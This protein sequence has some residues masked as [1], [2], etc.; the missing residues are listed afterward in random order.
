MVLIFVLSCPGVV[1]CFIRVVLYNRGTF[2]WFLMAHVGSGGFR[3]DVGK[4][5]N[6][7][8]HFLSSTRRL[9]SLLYQSA[10]SPL[11]IV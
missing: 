4:L 11:G 8:L 1:L 3:S 5:Q 10:A 7:R 9:Y 2:R 6:N